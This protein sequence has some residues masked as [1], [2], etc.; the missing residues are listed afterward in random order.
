MPNEYETTKL[1]AKTLKIIR[2]LAAHTGQSMVSIMHRL[3]SKELKRVLKKESDRE[4][5]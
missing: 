2:L 5:D 4:E 1:W 3:A